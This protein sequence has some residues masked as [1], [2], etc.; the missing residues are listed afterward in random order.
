MLSTLQFCGWDGKRKNEKGRG[1]IGKNSYEGSKMQR[2]RR[3]KRHSEKETQPNYRRRTLEL[4][5]GS[6]SKF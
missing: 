6:Q 4:R 5:E 2:K 1:I 3:W